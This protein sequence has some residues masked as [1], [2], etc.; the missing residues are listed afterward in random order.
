MKLFSGLSACLGLTLSLS[1][2]LTVPG[3]ADAT[4]TG[5]VFLDYN[6]NGLGDSANGMT[7][8]DIAGVTVTLYDALGTSVG[9]DTTDISGNYTISVVNDGPFRVEFTDIPDNLVPSSAGADNGSTVQFVGGD[10]VAN[11]ALTD[12][13]AY[14]DN[15]AMLVTSCYLA[16][17]VDGDALV[18]FPYSY[19][20]N[21]NGFGGQPNPGFNPEQD[22]W[23]SRD[24]TW[25][26]TPF[27]MNNEVGTTYGIAYNDA[28]DT[29]YSGS[30][31]R[32]K[33]KLGGLSG[34]STGAIY[35]T[36]NL[37]TGT[38]TNSVFADLNEIFGANTAGQNPHPSATTNFNRDEETVPFVGK[39]GLGDVEISP[40]NQTVY[41]VN[42]A[43]NN[44]YSIPVADPTSATRIAIPTLDG[45]EVDTRPFA[46]KAASDRTLYVGAV[47]SAET[48][49]DAEDLT[50]R[51]WSF[52]GMNFMPV[53]N[54]D[55]TAYRGG[56][57]YQAWRPWAQPGMID[58]TGMTEYPQPMLVDLE[59]ASDGDMILGFRDRY[60][61]QTPGNDLFPSQ[62]PFP[63]GYGDILRASAD[64]DGT[65]TLNSEYYPLEKSGGIS[66][67]MSED[68]IGND[69]VTSGA[70]AYNSQ[71][72]EVV[73]TAYDPVNQ[74]E[75]GDT[76]TNNFNTGGV[77][78]Y[79]EDGDQTGAYGVYLASY[80]DTM[81][82]TNGLG[83]LELICE[84]APLEIGNFVW[85]DA[86][87][88]GIQD[89]GEN[90][91]SGVELNLLDGTDI[92]ATA[93]TDANGNYIF[94]S[95]AA[96]STEAMIYNLDL[97]TG[98]DYQVAIE[99]NQ[100]ELDGYI[101]TQENIEEGDNADSIDSDG[102]LDGG[103]VM[104]M[105]D[106]LEVGANHT[107]DFGFTG[108]GFGG[109]EP[110]G[111]IGDLVFMDVNNNGVF[112]AGDTEMSNI[113]VELWE[114]FD[115]D[116]QPD[117]LLEST[118][119]DENGGYL[120]EQLPLNANYVVRVNDSQVGTLL[121]TRGEEGINNNSPDA[122]GY[123]VSL[124]IDASEILT[125]DFGFYQPV[126]SGG[127]GPEEP[128]E[129]E[130]PIM[131]GAAPEEPVD[132]EEVPTGGSSLI[133]T[134]GNLLSDNST[135]I[136]VFFAT[137]IALGTYLYKAD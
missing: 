73:V 71:T 113:N 63:R 117:A 31:I 121:N 34:E 76:I 124:S 14:C 94:S 58:A 85:L 72:Q 86:N 102:I 129:P 55:F 10:G 100:D 122:T 51:V 127:A 64:G 78:V 15:N 111:T 66:D 52:D 128:A 43:D 32:R 6:A 8:T 35:Q 18:K 27:A 84:S 90:P 2:F 57:D 136:F 47:C 59:I 104:A 23:V 123:C 1:T 9:T 53:L 39:A 91:L 61:D 83:D 26:P 56:D 62:A 17:N 132:E 46:L 96:E 89:A 137:V 50:A 7:D 92:V 101:L 13:E 82:K 28:S 37:I 134:G 74:D 16:G 68:A 12:P 40:D 130:E 108:G 41:T 88:N 20:S 107:F 106:S 42:L 116:C 99:L 54:A 114:D 29:L 69:E 105:V 118:L 36:S 75:N 5:N 79:G 120:F 109:V 70:L 115:G 126:A 65:F 110:L 80:Q 45:C 93:T 87:A 97:Q 125:A 25:M 131:G 112:D 24:D 81:G 135:Y 19:T 11:L 49:Q 103:M 21:L 77:Q 3:V 33:A 38:P 67:S 95:R 60:G 119:T 133:R 4:V 22:T 98:N 48:S 44:L 30:F